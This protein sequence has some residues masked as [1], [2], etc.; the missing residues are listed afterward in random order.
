MNSHSAS[1]YS[2]ASSRDSSARGARAPRARGRARRRGAPACSGTAEAMD[3]RPPIAL[4]VSSSSASRPCSRRSTNSPSRC[5][6]AAFQLSARSPMARVSAISCSASSKRPSMSASIVWPVPTCH[7]WAGWRSSS[8]S[9][10]IASSSAST[11]AR[12]VRTHR[13]CRR[14]SWPANTL[15][16]SPI[17][18][19][20]EI[21]SVCHLD[22]LRGEIQLRTLH[23]DP[24]PFDDGGEG[25]RVATPPRDVQRLLREPDPP[26]ARGI[27]ASRRGQ[28]DEQADA[29]E[30]L[31]ARRSRPGHAP[32][33]HQAGSALAR[34][35]A[36]LP[37]YPSAARAS[38]SASPP[39]SASS[40]ASRNACFDAGESPARASAS[41]SASSSSQRAS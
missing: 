16:L 24:V 8:A 25:C 2:P 30:A 33:G 10:R 22:R 34:T 3:T 13:Q 15:S 11:P 36:N 17:C 21:S 32:A 37:P 9:A 29:R 1:R 12:S 23:G 28:P 6:T 27:V 20:S 38:C 4:I 14:W 35:Q 7:C 39:R 5:D 19:P 40:A 26:I 18:S 31:V 41:P